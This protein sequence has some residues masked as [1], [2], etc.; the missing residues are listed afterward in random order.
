MQN[1]REYLLAGQVIPA[2]PLALNS[3]RKL[4]GR[5]QRALTR[6]YMAAG[7]GGLAVAVHTTQ[8]EIRDRQHG[9][10][11]PVLELASQTIDQELT[12]D[13][14]RFVKIAGVVG[15][16]SQAVGEAQLA[17]SL[18]Y[19]AALLGLGALRNASEQELID[20][21]RAIAEVIPVVGFYLQPA[22]G[23]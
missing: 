1:L 19:D 2:H 9:L 7:A 17:Q 13:P 6:Y 11:K 3:A 22:V 21:C 12:R 10:L 14:R 23:G 16:T 15:L 18:G 4:D 8:F 5:R 20:H